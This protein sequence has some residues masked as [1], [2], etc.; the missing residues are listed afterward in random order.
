MEAYFDTDYMYASKSQLAYASY[1]YYQY[2]N[3]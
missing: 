1:Q 2:L 3:D